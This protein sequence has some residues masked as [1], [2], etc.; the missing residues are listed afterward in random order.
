MAPSYEIHPA[1]DEWGQQV[2]GHYNDY[3]KVVKPRNACVTFLV[4]SGI[5][6][7]SSYRRADGLVF[8]EWSFFSK[9]Y[10]ASYAAAFQAH[11]R[12][13]RTMKLHLHY[14]ERLPYIIYLVGI[15]APVDIYVHT[16]Q[17]F[18]GEKGAFLEGGAFFIPYLLMHWYLLLVA[19]ASPLVYW[20][21]P[22][23]TWPLYFSYLRVTL[24]ANDF[25]YRMCVRKMTLA[26]RLF[27][28]GGFV[29]AMAGIGYAATL[30]VPMVL[31]AA[32]IE[33]Y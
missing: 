6:H 14:I 30:L 18:W 2:R 23:V 15:A 4:F 27:E 29:L 8:G 12:P 32:G 20:C 33:E 21:M 17:F 1:G 19:M 22:K 7:P 24:W 5:L 10:S 11:Q 3:R 9:T 31:A 26:R 13:Y 28:F 25:A 16:C